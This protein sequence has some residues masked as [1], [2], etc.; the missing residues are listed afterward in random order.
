MIAII[1]L[2]SHHY[3]LFRYI[4]EH[5][6]NKEI[7]IFT[8]K[9]NR[10]SNNYLEY[11]NNNYIFNI[12]NINFLKDNQDKYNKIIIITYKNIPEWFNYENENVYM[13]LHT[14][15]QHR[16]NPK[17]K[18]YIC[19]YENFSK[20]LKNIFPEKNIYYNL[21]IYNTIIKKEEQK[22]KDKILYI[23]QL[24]EY[25]DIYKQYGAQPEKFINFINNLNYEVIF[26]GFSFSRNKKLEKLKNIRIEE[27]TSLINL[28]KLLSETKFIIGRNCYPYEDNFSGSIA[29]SLSYEI[30]IIMKQSKIDEFDIIGIGYEEYYDEVIYLINNMNDDYYN[31][32]INK[33]KDIKEI[34]IS[35]NN[36][37]FAKYIFE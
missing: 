8:D 11:Y 25:F 9:K 19:L 36:N 30:P 20:K 18:N 15:Q 1:N 27:D 4:L 16:R 3:E 17:V 34:N 32:I 31:S 28:E 13:V 23:G 26:F 37:F 10:V 35:K 29:I 21:P 33:I 6:K 14:N 22:K 24:Y 12:Y 7:H 5:T 2:V